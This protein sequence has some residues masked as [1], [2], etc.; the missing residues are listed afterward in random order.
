MQLTYK[1]QMQWKLLKS[2]TY[3]RWRIMT[4]SFVLC[5]GPRSYWV[6]ECHQ[7]PDGKWSVGECHKAI[8]V[9]SDLQ[10]ALAYGRMLHLK[11][12]V[13]ELEPLFV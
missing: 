9:F 1:E 13:A 4:G 10:D 6:E 2:R 7:R 11:S 5:V 8:R 12:Q 3:P